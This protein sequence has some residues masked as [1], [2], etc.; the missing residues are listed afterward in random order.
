MVLN[1]FFRG[2]LSAFVALFFQWSIS[3]YV[4][5]KGDIF[6]LFS[7]PLAY[8]ISGALIE[9]LVKFGFFRVNLFKNKEFDDPVDAIIYMVS[10]AMGFAAVEN[11][12]IFLQ[13]EDDQLVSLFLMRFISATLLHAVAA[14]IIG[15]YFVQQ[16]VA[17]KKGNNKTRSRVLFIVGFGLAVLLHSIYNL[18]IH[19]STINVD[20]GYSLWLMAFLLLF[21]ILVA[22]HLTVRL[23]KLKLEKD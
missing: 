22:S 1:F 2:I 19:Y 14:A 20:L 18:I 3:R 9:E 10:V 17:T 11:V 5:L 15:Y 21:S 7:L 16:H 4:D 12:A 13:G 6:L 23:N 8:V